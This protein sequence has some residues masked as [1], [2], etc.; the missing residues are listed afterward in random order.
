MKK[1]TTYIGVLLIILGTLT[2]ALTR[3]NSL[4]N[5]NWLLLLGLLFIIFGI[6]MHIRKIK[7]ESNY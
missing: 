4:S 1:L 6:V 2:L 3:L 7:H 5:S